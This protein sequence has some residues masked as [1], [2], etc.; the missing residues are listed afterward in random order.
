MIGRIVRL[1]TS[2]GYGFI[3]ADD[4]PD[5]S[6]VFFHSNACACACDADLRVGQRVSF[7]FGTNR[8]TERPLARH[9]RPIESSAC[10]DQERSRAGR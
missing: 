9:V 10:R 3:V 4:A 1:M 6:Q 7:T 2:S 8:R 5:A